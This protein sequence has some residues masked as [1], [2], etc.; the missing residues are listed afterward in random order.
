MTE[1]ADESSV[2][3]AGLEG[4]G[5]KREVEEVAGEEKEPNEEDVSDAPLDP[6]L[7]KPND[8]C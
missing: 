2:G 3:A 7:P 8:G 5:P 4:A 6:K 1:E